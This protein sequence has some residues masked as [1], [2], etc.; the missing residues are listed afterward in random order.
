M[1]LITL[2]YALTF[3]SLVF[4]WFFLS[5]IVVDHGNTLEYEYLAATTLMPPIDCMIG[6]FQYGTYLIADGLLVCTPFPRNIL[7]KVF[8]SSAGMEVHPNVWRILQFL[9]DTLTALPNR[10]R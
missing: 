5:W 9:S 4:Q 8:T 7:F 1:L 6:V 2:L 3:A 10:D